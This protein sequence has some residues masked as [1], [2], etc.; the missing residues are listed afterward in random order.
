MRHAMRVDP[1]PAFGAGQKGFAIGEGPRRT[2]GQIVE[3]DD[4]APRVTQRGV[5]YFRF[6]NWFAR[7]AC[8]VGPWAGVVLTIGL[9]CG[10]L[11]AD[12]PTLPQQVP[13]ILG[14]AVVAQGNRDGKGDEWQVR[15]VVPKA[16]WEIVGEEVPK[17]RRPELRVEAVE[18]VLNLRMGGPSQ[19][20]ESRFVDIRGKELSRQQVEARLAKETPV[21][22][23]VSGSMPDV[24]FLRL[25][26]DDALI[27]LLG[28][29]DGQPAPELLPERKQPR[30]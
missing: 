4:E 16:R 22:V 15:V 24:S 11:A 2:V 5:C 25:T 18:V 13:P 20:A 29:R 14:T 9:A 7:R 3:E 28:P 30:R 8:M 12:S 26:K 27:I 10:A 19:L 6:V 23:S 1:T 21:L 17:E